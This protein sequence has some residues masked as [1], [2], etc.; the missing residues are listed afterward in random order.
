MEHEEEVAAVE[1]TVETPVVETP[2]ETSVETPVEAAA[3][4]VVDDA[5]PDVGES[6]TPDVGDVEWNGELDALESAPWFTEHVPE[7][8]RNVLM[9]GMKLKFRNVESGLTRATQ[10]LAEDRT[11]IESE[12]STAQTELAR[13]KRW[14]DN[15][16]DLGTQAMQ[17]ADELRQKIAALETAKTETETALR[18]EFDTE[19]EALRQQLIQEW[20]EKYNPVEAEK[21]RLE[22]E[23]ATLREANAAAEERRNAEVLDSITSWIDKNAPDLWED[24]NEEALLKFSHLLQTGAAVD[25]DEAI[26]VTAVF[27]PKFS[28][29]GPAEVPTSVALM[30]T[31]STTQFD[32]GGGEAK[33]K[34]YA[35]LKREMTEGARRR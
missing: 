6:V 23:L 10:K 19:K 14:L 9:T 1:T 18:G 5:A 26:K 29:D 3:E 16:E 21:A 31:E 20:E 34:S 17:E 22:Q 15:G 33:Q 30:S 8:Y 24:E 32:V 7:A 11:A 28:N 12:L 2:V 13:Y 27:F 25:P 35:E 4:T